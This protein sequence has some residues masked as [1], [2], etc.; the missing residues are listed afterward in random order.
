MFLVSET[1][2]LFLVLCSYP[3]PCSWDT[4]FGALMLGWDADGRDLAYANLIE[5]TLTRSAYGFVP[6]KR[7]GNAGDLPN[8]HETGAN[9][10]TSNDRTEPYVGAQ[11]LLRLHAK[12]R[13]DWVVELLFQTLLTWNQWAWRERVSH[14]A[15][16]LPLVQLGSDPENLPVYGSQ[17]TGQVGTRGAAIRRARMMGRSATRPPLREDHEKTAM[18]F[19]RRNQS[20]PPCSASIQRTKGC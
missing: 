17:Y 11:T 20:W 1:L 3:A 16:S 8:E 5:V 12:W 14:V 2:C 9:H 19:A 7:S 4:Y 15:M 10:V 6:N 18:A 13:D